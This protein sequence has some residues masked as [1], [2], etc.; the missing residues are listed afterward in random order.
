MPRKKPINP[1]AELEP[2]PSDVAVEAG[3]FLNFRV[4]A[5]LKKPP[6]ID[7]FPGTLV[8]RRY[9]AG[10][11]I[12]EQNQSGWTAFCILTTEDVLALRQ[13]QLGAAEGRQRQELEAEIS[14]LQ[15]RLEGLKDVQANA[16]GRAAATVYL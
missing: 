1:P 3:R 4:F 5:E 7:R 9:R 10:E 13:E 8:L 11:P 6:K 15:K 12:C 16:P 14:E 2:R